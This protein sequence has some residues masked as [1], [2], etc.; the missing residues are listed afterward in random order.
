MIPQ[1]QE[2]QSGILIPRWE[3]G[4]V[5]NDLEM[6]MSLCQPGPQRRVL[7]GWNARLSTFKHTYLLSPSV[8]LHCLPSLLSLSPNSS[9]CEQSR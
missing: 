1:D 2:E 3:F 4:S 6:E 8:C 7:A 9:P 5:Y